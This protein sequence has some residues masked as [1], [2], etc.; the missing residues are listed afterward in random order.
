[1]KK[2]SKIFI[3][4]FV[5]GAFLYQFRSSLLGEFVPIIENLQQNIW[6]FFFKPTP[7]A[8]PIQ[9]KL[10]TFDPQFNISK[11]YFLSAITSAELIW[12]KPFGK[13][14]FT[15]TPNNQA[16]NVLKINLIYDYRQQATS[17]LASLGIVVKDT[18]ASYET[19]KL[20]FTTLKIEYEQEKINFNIRVQSFNQKQLIY[21]QEVN[22]SN[23]KG[24][25][26]QSEYNRLEST[27]IMLQNESNELQIMQT[28]INNMVDELNALVVVL[29]HLATTLNLS[30]ERYNTVNGSRGESFEEGVY[31]SDGFNKEIDIYEFS[32]REKLVRVLTHELGHALQLDHVDDPKAIMYKLNQGNNLAL[33]E[34]DLNALKLRC[35]QK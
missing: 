18:R 14:L 23:K 5:L 3:F 30:V 27:R 22:L 16:T 12:E 24:G 6:G 26:T 29:N 7:C 25:A 17:K 34:T 9:Y 33:T 2:T 15:Y 32:S 20:K 13:D 10:D 21:Q 1:M 19:L 31:S 28:N 35:P 11:D 4:I 8:K